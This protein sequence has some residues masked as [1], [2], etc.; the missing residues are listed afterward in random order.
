MKHYHSK[1]IDKTVQDGDCKFLKIEFFAQITSI[2]LQA[3]KKNTIQEFFKKTRL[4]TFNLEIV[5]QKLQDL[6]LLSA[7]PNL[8]STFLTP[9]QVTQKTFFITP[10]TVCAFTLYAS[11]FTNPNYSFLS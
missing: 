8:P 9:S 11:T 10:T 2:C 7:E 6:L 3:F 4:I 1:T 5:M